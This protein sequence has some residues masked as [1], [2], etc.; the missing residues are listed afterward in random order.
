M[1]VVPV[2]LAIVGQAHFVVIKDEQR[3]DSSSSRKSRS[4]PGYG[5]SGSPVSYTGGRRFIDGRSVVSS[6]FSTVAEDGNDGAG[7]TNRYS[8][9]EHGIRN[10]AAS[11]SSGVGTG[12]ASLETD[13]G[14]NANAAV[15]YLLPQPLTVPVRQI[16]VPLA[17]ARPVDVPSP[18]EVE[19]PQPIRVAV[20]RSY[21]VT[22]SQPY[23]VHVPIR[24][25]V[26]VPVQVP[27][28]VP[29]PVLVNIPRPYPVDALRNYPVHVPQTA[30]VNVPVAVNV[31]SSGKIRLGSEYGTK[32][33]FIR[34]TESGVESE[35]AVGYAD[36]Y[37]SSGYSNGHVYSW[38][39]RRRHENIVAY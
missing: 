15:A 13:A 26:Q 30:E 36:G 10:G 6:G 33:G 23:L 5:G 24:V 21:P 3:L 39:P 8:N 28:E 38:Q 32:R 18:V 27:V 7:Y 35:S 20:P 16:H 19:V 34:D 14:N 25:P 1:Q 2:I 31:Q 37:S 22:I 29:A 12:S 4:S 17:V 11:I 9:N